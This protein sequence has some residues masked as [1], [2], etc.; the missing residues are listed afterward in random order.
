MHDNTRGSVVASAGCSYTWRAIMVPDNDVIEGENAR[1][2][3]GGGI[4]L[5][6]NL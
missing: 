1:L 5:Y 6:M 3:G 2:E 4:V